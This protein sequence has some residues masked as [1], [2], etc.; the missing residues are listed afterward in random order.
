MC[1]YGIY[2]ILE[3]S[4]ECPDVGSKATVL[5]NAFILVR[6]T[7]KTYVSSNWLINSI[8]TNPYKMVLDM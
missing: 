2:C 4:L 5:L 3:L 6:Y 1:F 8:F 7:F